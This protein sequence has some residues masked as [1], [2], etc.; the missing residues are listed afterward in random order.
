MAL[1][2]YPL[3]TRQAQAIPLEVARV[4]GSFR[5]TEAQGLV[6]LLLSGGVYSLYSPTFLKVAFGPNAV[7]NLSNE[8]ALDS[9]FIPPLT[10]MIVESVHTQI[11]IADV[12][13]L[14]DG[15]LYGTELTVWRALQDLEE[16]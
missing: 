3:R 13:G 15:V 6:S 4:K 2:Y 10:T 12:A 7:A 9:L 16:V 8:V 11:A 1:E 14:G 5:L